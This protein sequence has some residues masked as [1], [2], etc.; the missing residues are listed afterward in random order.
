MQMDNDNFI[1]AFLS[2]YESNLWKDEKDMYAEYA[3]YYYFSVADW[4]ISVTKWM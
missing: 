3:D 2:F 4:T 1:D